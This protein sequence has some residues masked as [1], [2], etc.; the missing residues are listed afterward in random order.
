MMEPIEEKPGNF[1]RKTEGMNKYWEYRKNIE[2]GIP[3]QKIANRYG[4]GTTTIYR[5]VNKRNESF[6]G[7]MGL[8]ILHDDGITGRTTV[9]ILEA[10]HEILAN[11]AFIEDTEFY[12]VVD[13]FIDATDR[14]IPVKLITQPDQFV[15]R[16]RNKLTHSKVEVRLVKYCHNKS[17]ITDNTCLIGSANMKRSSAQWNFNSGLFTSD[18][19]AVYGERVYFF[20]RFKHGKL[21]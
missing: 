1:S 7:G 9:M 13:A 3:V 14:G 6:P 15:G 19:I 2:A 18:A 5:V 10:K 11:M 21:P 16:L 12:P 17:V 8:E 20:Q 4:I